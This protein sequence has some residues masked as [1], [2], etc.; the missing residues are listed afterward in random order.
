MQVSYSMLRLFFIR[1]VIDAI[2]AILCIQG[3]DNKESKQ[4]A[5][6]IAEHSTFAV[7]VQE[8][9]RG[10]SEWPIEEPACKTGSEA[11]A[12]EEIGRREIARF[13]HNLGAEFTECWREN[14]DRVLLPIL[15]LN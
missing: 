14:W 5:F 2:Y 8:L 4:N 7:H 15:L 9:F 12:R 1:C 13:R 3:A 11:A 10:L 6:T